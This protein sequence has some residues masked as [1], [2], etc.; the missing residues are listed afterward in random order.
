MRENSVRQFLK[1]I[2]PNLALVFL[3]STAAWAAT[4]H[5]AHKYN[6]SDLRNRTINFV[7]FTGTLYFLLRKPVAKFF[8]ERTEKIEG[9]FKNLEAR[10]T[11][12]SKRLNDVEASIANLEAE[13]AAIMADYR[14]QGEAL[15]KSLVEKA[16]ET[17]RQIV[18]Q[19]RFAAENE[20]KTAVEDLRARMADLLAEAAT[21]ML[22]DKLSDKD[23]EKLIDKYL[24][25]VVLQ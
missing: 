7:L 6:W 14:A 25:K 12:A 22:K 19:A 23:H 16:E 8:R 15:Q 18:E 9:E 24:E 13:R 11:E 3:I 5:L 1:S 17:A 21:T 4:D 2:L 20:A 10:K